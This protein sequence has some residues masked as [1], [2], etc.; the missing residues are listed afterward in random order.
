MNFKIILT[1][2]SD[3]YLLKKYLSI[4][5]PNINNNEISKIVDEFDFGKFLIIKSNSIVL[6]N[7]ILVEN[8][9]R[10]YE[11]YN[12]MSI[13]EKINEKSFV[14]DVHTIQT[15]NIL[16]NLFNKN[17]IKY[18]NYSYYNNGVKFIF[19]GDEYRLISN[20][21]YEILFNNIK[22]IDSDIFIRNIKLKKL[23]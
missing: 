14:I 17:K 10:D 7:G 9:L 11:F 4:L 2:P 19:N 6:S 3:K 1:K 16:L 18:Y 13:Y 20:D 21:E 12:S 8:C 5:L 15:Y 23:L 22:L